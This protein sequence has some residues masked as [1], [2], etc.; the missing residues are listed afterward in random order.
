MGR[1]WE[2]QINQIKKSPQ[3]YAVSSICKFGAI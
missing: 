1:E 3:R 2:V